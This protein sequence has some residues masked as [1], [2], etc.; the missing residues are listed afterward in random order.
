MRASSGKKF[1]KG[2]I[3]HPGSLHTALN[4]PQGQTIPRAK[5]TAA[6]RSGSANLRKKA[7]FALELEGFG[8]KK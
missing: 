5:I 6:A 4:V 1:I 7:Q 8:K 3:K 2:A